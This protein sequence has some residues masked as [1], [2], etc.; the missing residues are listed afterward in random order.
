MSAP[1]TPGPWEAGQQDRV[2]TGP[3]REK[4]AN[5]YILA[6]DPDGSEDDGI[7]IA[8]VHNDAGKLTEANAHLMCAAQDLYESLAECVDEMEAMIE[9]DAAL[10][11][12][13]S[14]MIDRARAALKKA[15]G[16]K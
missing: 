7:A 6:P 2:L 8:A 12:V 9:E 11:D 15:R 14:R 3:M 13:W 1:G 16:D 10:R 5:W 4:Y